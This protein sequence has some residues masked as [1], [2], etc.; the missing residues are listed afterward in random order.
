[1]RMND[2]ARSG[3]LETRWSG[4]ARWLI[5]NCSAQSWKPAYDNGD[6]AEATGI[7][8]PGNDAFAGRRATVAPHAA[9]RHRSD[10]RSIPTADA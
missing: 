9:T 10:R 3:R 2:F 7:A 8:S 4:S 1:M 5:S 6:E